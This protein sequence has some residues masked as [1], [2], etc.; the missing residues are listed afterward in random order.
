MTTGLRVVRLLGDRS[1]PTA[2]L[3]VGA[4]AAE[5]GAPLSSVSRLCAELERTGLIE[6]GPV[7]G[8]YRLGSAAVRLSGRAAAPFARSLRFA[9]TLAAQQ[10]GETVVLAAGAPGSVRV[11]GSVLSSWTL[12]S[13]AAVG[14]RIEE[15]G[16]A[17]ARAAD[18]RGLGDD[19]VA[20]TTAGLR[21]EI[22]TPLLAPAGEGVAVLAVRLPAIRLRENGP[23]IHR[24]L[25]VAR[26]SIE[27]GLGGSR[28]ADAAIRRSRPPADRRLRAARGPAAPAAPRRRA[29][30]RGRRRAGDGPPPRPHRPAARCVRR[31]GRGRARR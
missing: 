18:P 12:H 23:R 25:A 9:L 27:A 5:L 11:I 14:E 13:P 26:R 29:G 30:H 19:A 6:R 4:I 1:D 17:I 10:T 15:A 7:Y 20:E 24:A 16:S 3:G 31:G 8:S 28:A 21:V 22:A 2:P